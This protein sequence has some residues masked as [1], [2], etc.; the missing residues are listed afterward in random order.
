MKTR[1]QTLC[2]GVLGVIFLMLAACSGGGGSGGSSGANNGGGFKGVII[3]G[4]S[5][6]FSTPM[7]IAVDGAGN[8]WIPN[9]GNNSVTELTKSSNYSNTG[10]VNISGGGEGYLLNM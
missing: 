4:G 7:G 3:S 8:I 9:Y 2:C 6:N 1:E 5:T 10:A